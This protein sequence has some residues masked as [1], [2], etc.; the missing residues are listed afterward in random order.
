MKTRQLICLIIFLTAIATYLNLSKPKKNINPNHLLEGFSNK[1]ISE[2]REDEN[3]LIVF[4][5]HNDSV[6]S[7]LF[8][9]VTNEPAIYRND[10]IQIKKKTKLTEKSRVLD[11][12]CGLGRHMEIIKELVPKIKIEGIDKSKSMINK[13]RIRN[14][15]SELLC[16]SLTIPEIYKKEKLSHILCLHETLHHNNPREINKILK[17]FHKWLVPGGYLVVHIFDPKKLDPGPREFSQYFKDD[18]G[19]RHSL[20][21]FESFT[22]EAWW[23]KESEKRDWYKY[24]EKYIFPKDKIKIQTT[25]LWIPPV[26]KMLEYIS[27]HDFKLHE[28]IELKDVEITDFTLYVFKKK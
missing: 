2:D 3:K 9:L 22:H 16:T 19:T 11:A 25:P 15:G 20:T 13:C 27:N 21:Y 26:N 1:N 6:Y 12:G 8:E 17:N 18:D 28:I 23:E 5:D 4:P 7:R 14:P 24:C 10:I